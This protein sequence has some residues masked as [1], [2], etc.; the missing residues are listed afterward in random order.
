MPALK[1]SGFTSYLI[2]TSVLILGIG[3]S[4]C[5]SGPKIDYSTQVKPILN[6][7]CIHCHGGVK[8]NGG[9][10]LLN[11]ELAMAPTESEHPAIIPFDAD[12]SELIKRL[13]HSNPEKRMPFE[14]DALAENEVEI[15][16]QWI[17]EGAE[18]GTH[19]AYVPLK[20]VEVPKET[21][22]ADINGS[23]NWG[24]NSIDAFIAQKME[25]KGLSPN[26]EAQKEVLL[27]RLSFDLTGLPASDELREAFLREEDPISYEVVIDSLLA[28]QSYGERWAAMWMDL[29]RYAD[30]KGFE[31]D[32]SRTIW[33]YRDYVIRSFNQDLP[34]DQFIIEQMAGDLLPTP[35]DAQYIATGFHRNT[36]TNDEGGTNNE[37]FRTYAIINRVNTT[38]EA[39]MGTTFSCTQCH[40]HPYDPIPH[41]EYYEFMAFLNN[42][43]DNDTHPDYPWLRMFSEVEKG[44]LASLK[45]WVGAQS[46]EEKASKIEGFLKTWQPVSYS[47]ETDSMVNA[48]LYDTKY[49]GFRYKGM[50]RFRHLDL[51]G[52]DAFLMRVL[53]NGDGGKIRIHIDAP[54][55]KKILDAKLDKSKAI[56]DFYQFPI[57][58]T[59]GTHD[60][61]IFYDNPRMASNPDAMGF[62]FD[63]FTFV[64]DLPGK[65]TASYAENEKRFWE[66]MQ[67]KA[68]HS[69]IMRENPEDRRRKT[70][71]FDRGNWLVAEQEVQPD[72]PGILPDFPADA[73]RNRL[74]LAQWIVS[75]ENPLTA[76]TIV[77][78][79]WE[80]IFGQG[81]A[82]TLEDLGSQ[83]IPPSHPELLDYLAWNF[84]HTHN[85]SIKGLL[86]EILLSDTYR[87]SSVVD[88]Q[89]R[90]ADPYNKYYARGARVRLSA[91]Q[92]RDQALAVSDLL[93]EKMYGPP[94]MPYQPEGVWAAPYNSQAWKISEGEDRFRRALYTFVKRGSPYPA[95][96]T[97]DVA[98]REVCSSRR[99]RTNTPLQALLTLNDPVY[100]EAAQN[101][102]KW[103]EKQGN[104]SL[105]EKISI[106]YMRAV[107]RAIPADK[108]KVFGDLYEASK[109]NY[110]Q[111]EEEA[112]ELLGE[113]E[114]EEVAHAAAMV[115]LANAMFNLDEF[116]TK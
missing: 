63:W 78:R 97:F 9:F 49:L 62:Q 55:G 44:E 68:D 91:E 16:R 69:L 106:A 95:M 98:N 13:T 87:Q 75:T 83:G 59:T 104:S 29:A 2:G 22:R 52:K 33:E 94:V 4:A 37:E 17:E 14:K 20:E 66:L 113:W 107:G 90:D 40:G 89:K 8:Q 39:L 100:V 103:I 15:L 28:S 58:K 70:H 26:P 19:W 34:Y 47:L 112:K 60:L 84:M 111:D 54:A 101:F 43:R 76:R 6:K 25:E 32:F 46:S 116:L 74:G 93:S 72:V 42:T 24:A 7:N 45:K 86:K 51:S 79:L 50:A 96:E 30:S 85:W 38:W 77:N 88:A 21:L 99:I 71:V 10:S 36:T 115:M 48:A 114:N 109:E 53:R 35:T 65:G 5:N 57:E 12:N 108:L 41:E 56:A 23:E 1:L 61:Y 73:P 64:E 80:Q 3:L 105:E 31:R 27:R 11:R 81:L 82:E 67:S 18:W 102:A 110:E 92:I